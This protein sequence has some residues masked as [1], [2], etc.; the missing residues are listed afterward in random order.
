MYG[1]LFIQQRLCT[2]VLLSTQQIFNLI[3]VS[4]SQSF[5]INQVKW[6]EKG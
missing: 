2:V 5:R 1:D 6:A 4:F 3:N